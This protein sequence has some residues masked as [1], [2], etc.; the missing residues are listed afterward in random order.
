[1]RCKHRL[2]AG[3]NYGAHGAPTKNSQCGPLGR[4]ACELLKQITLNVSTPKARPTQF[5]AA[6]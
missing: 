6:S 3:T 2:Q 1:M 5:A 4:R